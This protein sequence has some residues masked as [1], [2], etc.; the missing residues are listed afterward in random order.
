MQYRVNEAIV[1][2]GFKFYEKLHEPIFLLNSVGQ[3][4]KANEAARKLTVISKKTIQEIEN[5]ITEFVSDVHFLDLNKV[6]RVTNKLLPYHLTIRPLE[7][8]QFLLMEVYR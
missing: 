4:L 5:G 2:Q 7:G 8:T 1:E 6:R 3:I